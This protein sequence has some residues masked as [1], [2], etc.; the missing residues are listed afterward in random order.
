MYT[1]Y[2]LVTAKDSSIKL[3][4]MTKNPAK[5]KIENNLNAFKS[6]LMKFYN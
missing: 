2:C 5:N 6:Y 1:L 4:I 3:G